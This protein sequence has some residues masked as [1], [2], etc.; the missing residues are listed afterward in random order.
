MLGPV[1]LPGAQI[2]GQSVMDRNGGEQPLRIPTVYAPF[3]SGTVFDF[4]PGQ[5]TGNEPGVA[6]RL[7]NITLVLP[8]VTY[9]ELST[10][11]FTN[12]FNLQDNA[13]V[14]ITNRHASLHLMYTRGSVQ[15]CIRVSA[16]TC[17]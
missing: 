4:G 6:L 14:C 2:D 13:R 12:F 1:Q 9:S 3:Q 8:N 7:S 5:Q 16:P 10:S 17:I 11:G 15:P